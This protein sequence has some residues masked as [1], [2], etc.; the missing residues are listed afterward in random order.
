LAATKEPKDVQH[1]ERLLEQVRA[2]RLRLRQRA[3]ALAA[4]G[5][6]RF[7]IGGKN[8]PSDLEGDENCGD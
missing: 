5:V 6:R 7:V 8:G 1:I 2:E 3:N 4:S